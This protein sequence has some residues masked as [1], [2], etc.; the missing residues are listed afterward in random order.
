MNRSIERFDAQFLRLNAAIAALVAAS[1]G[2]FTLLLPFDFMLRKLRL[3]GLEWL[4]E[5]AE[6]FLYFGVF[7][8]AAWVLQRGAHVRVDIV[9]TVLP[10][11]AAVILERAMDIFGAALCLAMAYFG[12]RGGYFSY[13]LETLPDKDLRIPNWIILAVFC[14]SFVLL[15]VE[16]LL[17]F[18]RTM[19]D[20][21]IQ[22]TEMGF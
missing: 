14:V 19:R 3:G 17:R 9:L 20:G 6:Y 5:G 13:L 15:A 1:V 11:R 16:F 12:A 4:N 2:A 21:R 7:L 22:D 10:R 8:S 18:Y